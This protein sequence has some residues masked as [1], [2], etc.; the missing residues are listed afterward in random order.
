MRKKILLI[1]NNNGLEGVNV[2]FQNYIQFFKS[3]TGGEWNDGEIITMMNPL[4]VL[5]N[6]QI[7]NLKRENLDYLIVIFSGH[8]GQERE[9]VLELNN[10]GESIEESA[11]KYISTRQL[12]IYDCCRSYPTKAEAATEKMIR[13]FDSGGKIF[14][15]TRARYEVRIMSSI[16]QQICLYACSIGETAEDTKDGGIYSSS[17]LQS[18]AAIQGSTE[19]Y[20]FVGNTH[21]S[22]KYIV[23][24]K[25]YKQNP[26][27]VLPRCLSN[28]QLIFSINPQI[29]RII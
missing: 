7:A 15:S 25:G 23:K 21:I 29:H 10:K 26:D 5:L 22:A 2:D 28:Q 3:K 24:A 18:G 17:L 9:T 1:G 11:L 4:K 6:L 19:D 20:S 12:N 14:Y 16:S 27:A 13:L 8:G